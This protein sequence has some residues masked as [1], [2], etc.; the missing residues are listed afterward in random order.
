MTIIR[1][2]S[3][4]AAELL[5]AYL[6]ERPD[7]AAEITGPNTL[8]V[9][10]LGPIETMLCRWSSR[11]ASGHGRRL[12]GPKGSTSAHRSSPRQATSPTRGIVS[13]STACSRMDRDPSSIAEFKRP[14]TR[15]ERL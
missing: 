1:L 11:S 12:P 8:S 5:F 9:S 14:T 4:L 15:G 10:V 6:R 2:N 3:A 7:I 13:G